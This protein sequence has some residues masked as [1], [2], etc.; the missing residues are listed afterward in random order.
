MFS[1]IFGF[2]NCAVCGILAIVVMTSVRHNKNTDNCNRNREDLV[3]P[4][5]ILQDGDGKGIGEESGAVVDRCQVTC[6]GQINCHVPCGTSN[7]ESC[8]D[9]RRRFDQ[10]RYNGPVLVVGWMHFLRFS[11][12]RG[13]PN[14][15]NMT[16]P[17]CIPRELS[18]L[19]AENK[20]LNW[21]DDDP[22]T[23]CK[24]AIPVMSNRPFYF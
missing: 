8:G 4:Q 13:C 22:R 16:S 1:L 12:L 14:E 21:P 5:F 23:M 17:K 3:D 18:F 19:Y 24:V 11:H 9:E 2:A 7:G 6:R 15:E 20:E 10:V